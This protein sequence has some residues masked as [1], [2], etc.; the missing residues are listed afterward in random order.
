MPTWQVR[1]VYDG[2]YKTPTLP[3][4]AF[5]TWREPSGLAPLPGDPA[6]DCAGL[7]GRA[8]RLAVQLA[9]GTDG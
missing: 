3:S 2:E 8:G 5:T 1:D 6:V 4:Q 7:I 9:T